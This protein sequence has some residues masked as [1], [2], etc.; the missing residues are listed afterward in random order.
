[1]FSAL[2]LSVLDTICPLFFRN[3]NFELLFPQGCNRIDHFDEGV[4]F[5]FRLDF[6]MMWVP[7]VYIAPNK[8]QRFRINIGDPNNLVLRGYAVESR[9]LPVESSLLYSVQLCGF[10]NQSES[11]QFRWL[12]TSIAHFD[13]TFKDIAGLDNVQ[14]SYEPEDGVRMVLL[15]D[16]FESEGLK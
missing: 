6:E 12:Q 14:I 9:I 7:I 4:E 3:V 16:S 1:M 11:I 2:Q 10:S 8:P 15:E 13:N 5:A